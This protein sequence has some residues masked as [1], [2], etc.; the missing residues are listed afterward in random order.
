MSLNEL[1]DSYRNNPCERLLT[2]VL[3]E[4][5][6]LIYGIAFNIVKHNQDAEDLT[7]D[8]LIKVIQNINDLPKNTYFI[9]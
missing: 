4:S 1:F 8:V 2:E 5:Q 7:Q 3:K 9:P 6:S